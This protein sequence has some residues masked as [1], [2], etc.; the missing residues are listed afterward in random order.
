[1]SIFYQVQALTVAENSIQVLGNANIRLFAEA[2]R[3][4]IKVFGNISVGE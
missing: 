2:T 1:M 4:Q 3:D